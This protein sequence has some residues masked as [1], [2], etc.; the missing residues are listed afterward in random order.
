MK[1]TFAE[2]GAVAQLPDEVPDPDGMAV[3]IRRRPDLD[4]ETAR[5]AD[6]LTADPLNR[7]PAERPARHPAHRLPR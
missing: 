7:P 6:H 3:A 1:T 4:T 5:I 2:D